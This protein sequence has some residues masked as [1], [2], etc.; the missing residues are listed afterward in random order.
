[1]N[2][3]PMTIGVRASGTPLAVHMEIALVAPYFLVL[4]LLCTYGLH[5][6]HLVWLCWKFRRQAETQGPPASG[7]SSDQLPTVT[8][9]LPLY[10]EATL[11]SCESC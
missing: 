10:N 2:Y 3:I 8:V 7:F 9:Q 4:T 11:L 6:A 1:M 5:R